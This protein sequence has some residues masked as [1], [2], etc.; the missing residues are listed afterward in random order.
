M[1]EE[2]ICKM[3]KAEST[4][5]EA[6]IL[7]V[8]NNQIKIVDEIAGEARP[9]SSGFA[10]FAQKVLLERFSSSTC[11]RS[12]VAVDPQKVNHKDRSE[13]LSRADSNHI[14]V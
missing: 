5:E 2:L 6:F 4:N 8:C 3:G 14:V 11:T 10:F 7:N 13:E 9:T 12:T 1:L